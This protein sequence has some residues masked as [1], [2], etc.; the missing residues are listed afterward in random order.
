MIYIKR[1]CLFISFFFSSFFRQ[2]NCIYTSCDTISVEIN[3]THLRNE[4]NSK[5]IWSVKNCNWPMINAN[6]DSTMLIQCS[7]GNFF[8]R[9]LPQ[10]LEILNAL[11]IIKKQTNMLELKILRKRLKLKLALVYWDRIYR[12][13]DEQTF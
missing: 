13:N 4:Q 10:H 3:S 9:C 6:I 8:Y 12:E 2:I 11:K 1:I 7:W 5:W